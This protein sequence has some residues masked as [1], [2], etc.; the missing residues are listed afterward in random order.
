MKRDK[1][2]GTRIGR[3]GRIGAD[4]WK[5]REDGTRIEE[6][7]RGLS[8]LSGLG[9]LARMEEGGEERGRWDADAT[10]ERGYSENYF[11][12]FLSKEKIIP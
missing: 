2:N 7:G 5:G 12:C 1:G 10:G 3:I 9:G 4:G 6:M 11:N 8:G